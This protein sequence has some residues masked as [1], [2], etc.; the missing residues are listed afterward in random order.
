MLPNESFDS[1]PPD[2]EWA[3]LERP[4]AGFE[5]RRRRSEC[6]EIERFLPPAGPR[7]AVLVELVHADLEFRLRAGELARVEEYSRRFPELEARESVIASLI[8]AEF[9]WRR[10]R[11]P[12]LDREE[13]ARRFDRERAAAL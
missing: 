12:G 6:P 8:T 10:D 1:A 2:G 9:R 13:Y 3:E 4:V 11:E 5:R 7:R